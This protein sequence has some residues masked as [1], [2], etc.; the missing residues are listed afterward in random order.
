MW[1]VM[2]FVFRH[3]LPCLLIWAGLCLIAA[4][5]LSKAMRR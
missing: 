3:L 2:L 4:G 5:L 1:N